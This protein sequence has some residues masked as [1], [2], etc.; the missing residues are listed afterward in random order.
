MQDPSL[1]SLISSHK[2]QAISSEAFR[3]WCDHPVTRQLYF[4]IAS[5][6]LDELQEDLPESIPVADIGARALARQ[7]ALRTAMSLIEWNPV[8]E[9]GNEE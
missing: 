7:Y 1:V 3:L 2:P 9:E 4:D 8:D 5:T 6:M